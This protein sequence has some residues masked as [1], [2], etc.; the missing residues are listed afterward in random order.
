MKYSSLCLNGSMYTLYPLAHTMALPYLVLVHRTHILSTMFIAHNTLLTEMCD[1]LNNWL[2][3]LS[4]FPVS[5][6]VDVSNFP[7]HSSLVLVDLEVH[8]S[9]GRLSKYLGT[10]LSA[11]S[12]CLRSLRASRIFCLISTLFA[13]NNWS[14]ASTSMHLLPF[15]FT[16]FL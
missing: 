11:W 3:Q 16:L 12:A 9:L 8:T 6:P 1:A 4:C 14:T 13:P 7:L 10:S 5:S 15:Q 2:R